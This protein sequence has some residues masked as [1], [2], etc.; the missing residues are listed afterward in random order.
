MNYVRRI[1]E[2]DEASYHVI[3]KTFKIPI[4]KN[5]KTSNFNIGGFKMRSYT[6]QAPYVK[7]STARI[8]ISDSEGI[9]S[10]YTERY[11]KTIF[12]R[13]FDMW[14]G[15]NKFLSDHRAFNENGEKIIEAH[16]KNY[17]M[18]RSEYQYSF[19][20]GQYKGLDLV[21]RQKGIDI[22]SPIYEINGGD[23]NITTKKEILDWTKFY[24]NGKE[25]GRW[26]ISLQKN[27]KAHILIEEE[28]TIQDPLFYA[29][30]GQM[31][32]FIGD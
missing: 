23:I 12:H 25:I 8:N 20:G 9:N 11:F 2:F 21:A 28:A 3:G 7:S 14:V 24:E 15:E 18:K 32:Y 31:L 13:L 1:E 6:Y 4:S 17:T 30:A 19:L 29:I 16:K 27:L 26:K 5:Y 10:G 22:I